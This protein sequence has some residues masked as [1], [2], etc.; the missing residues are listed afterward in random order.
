[1]FFYI[2]RIWIQCRKLVWLEM[3]SVW[4]LK[5]FENK[6]TLLLKFI[7]NL[8]R[9]CPASELTGKSELILLQKKTVHQIG[10]QIVSFI[11]IYSKCRQCGYP[12]VP[13]QKNEDNP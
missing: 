1:M 7:F 12:V 9:T 11:I 2:L 3:Y 8:F 13:C 4:D 6:P 5:S 10:K